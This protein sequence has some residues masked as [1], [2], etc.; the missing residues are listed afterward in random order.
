MR[1]RMFGGPSRTISLDRVAHF[2]HVHVWYASTLSWCVCVGSGKA[3]PD[4]N[5]DFVS[6]KPSFGMPCVDA[7]NLQDGIGRRSRGTSGWH[8]YM[9]IG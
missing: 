1:A 5:V 4:E 2:G 3:A 8:E 6:V 7:S 9:A